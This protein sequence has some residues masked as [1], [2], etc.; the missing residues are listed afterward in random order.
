[1]TASSALRR[2]IKIRC[3]LKRFLARSYF[4]LVAFYTSNFLLENNLSLVSFTLLGQSIRVIYVKEV[5]TGKY[6]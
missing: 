6:R 3:C 5:V 1:M 4:R 2:D